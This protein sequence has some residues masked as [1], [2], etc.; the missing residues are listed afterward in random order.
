MSFLLSFLLFFSLS[1]QLF[2]AFGF[3]LLP[4]ERGECAYIF[5]FSL[6]LSLIGDY[7]LMIEVK[8]SF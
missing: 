2:S 8:F 3:R 4:P 1:S 5:Y 7:V 6:F